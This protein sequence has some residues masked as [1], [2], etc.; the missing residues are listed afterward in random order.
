MYSQTEA[1]A[2][3]RELLPVGA[4]VY[5]TVRSVAKSGMSRRISFFIVDNGAIRDLDF[6]LVQAG[7]GKH[8][9]NDNG[10]FV[11]GCGM[12]MCFAM[13]YEI[14]QAIHNDGYALKKIDL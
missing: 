6:L 13:V 11:T 10:L 4:T 7:L 1:K 12:D 2:K 3:L 9:G 5:T 14:G 8:R